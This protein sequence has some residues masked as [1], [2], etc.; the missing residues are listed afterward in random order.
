M[1]LR[2]TLVSKHDGGVM[3][4]EKALCQH[5]GGVVGVEKTLCHIKMQDR[6]DRVSREPLCLMF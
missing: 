3:G 4:I 2:P 6:G 5:N 1:K